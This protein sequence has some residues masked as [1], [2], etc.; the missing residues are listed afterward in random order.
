MTVSPLNL[1]YVQG[2][3]TYFS[4]IGT[5][6]PLPTLQFG[7]INCSPSNNE[8]PACEHNAKYCCLSNSILLVIE[9]NRF[10]G[11]CQT[12]G[13]RVIVNLTVTNITQLG[14]LRMTCIATN[15]AGDATTSEIVYIT[16]NHHCLF[17]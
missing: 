12:D 2:V 7:G 13:D 14:P 6:L 10:S 5:G 17:Y 1:S 16:G 9:G 8:L 11:Y 15:P 4:C 3:D